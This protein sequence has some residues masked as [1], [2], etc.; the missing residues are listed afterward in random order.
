MSGIMTLDDMANYS[1]N[2]RQP[3]VGFYRGMRVLTTPPPSSGPVLLFLLN[4]LEAYN[5][6]EEGASPLS[7]Q[8][9]ARLPLAAPIVLHSTDTADPASHCAVR[10]Q[11]RR[12]NEVCLCSAQLSRRSRVCRQ[13]EHDARAHPLQGVCLRGPPQHFQRTPLSRRIRVGFV[14]DTPLTPPRQTTTHEPDY[15]GGEYEVEETPGTTHI[16]VLDKDGNLASLTSTVR[17][18]RMRCSVAALICASLQINLS[19]GSKLM[20]RTGVIMNNQMDDFSTPN[21]TNAYGL[22]ASPAN[23]ISAHTPCWSPAA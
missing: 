18:F 12:G 11:H 21:T 6:H 13:H 22:R 16:A 3:L 20:S 7:Y 15:Y 5:L 8:Q 17:L 10:L 4:V 19:W 9:Y 2:R 1:V 23:Y 14:S